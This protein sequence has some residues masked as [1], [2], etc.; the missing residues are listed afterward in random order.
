VERLNRN[1]ANMMAEATNQYGLQQNNN[2]GISG[3][4]EPHDVGFFDPD[5]VDNGYGVCS[6][7]TMTR[8]TDVL[9]FCDHL[10]QLAATN[11]QEAVRR[12]WTQ[13]LLGSARVWYRQVLSEADR[14]LLH[15]ASVEAVCARLRERFKMDGS[16]ATDKIYDQRFTLLDTTKA[17]DIT[18]HVLTMVRYAKAV[19]MTPKM[20]PVMA[21][22]S[23]GND[24]QSELTKPDD[25]TTIDMF[26]KNIKARQSVMAAKARERAWCHGRRIG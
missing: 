22:N 25:D 19:E 17:R 20:Q 24:I 4:L 2:N 14:Q 3:A 21:F 6:D 7:G 12:V 1:P 16:D 8:Y 13:R 23:F 18:S 11:S 5:A 26:L 9:Y 10:T 15:G